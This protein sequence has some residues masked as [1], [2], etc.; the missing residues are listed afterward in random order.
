MNCIPEEKFKR[1]GIFL[2]TLKMVKKAQAAFDRGER[3]YD[4]SINCLADLTPDEFAKGFLGQGQLTGD[5]EGKAQGGVNIDPTITPVTQRIVREK[6]HGHHHH[7]DYHKPEY[8]TNLDWS[9]LGKARWM[10]ST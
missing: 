7:H 4:L 9:K 3:Q 6:Q 1:F 2:E 10:M 5:E 8:P